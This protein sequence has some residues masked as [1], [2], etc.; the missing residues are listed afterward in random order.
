[1]RV[2]RQNEP[3]ALNKLT[4]VPNLNDDLRNDA[5]IFTL[6]RTLAHNRYLLGRESEKELNIGN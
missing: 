5:C 6:V 3:T 1:M 2:A 4:S